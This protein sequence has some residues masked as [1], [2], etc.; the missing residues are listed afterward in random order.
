MVCEVMNMIVKNMEVTCRTKIKKTTLSIF[1]VLRRTSF[2]LNYYLITMAFKT[3]KRY[4]IKVTS[5]IF[6]K[7]KLWFH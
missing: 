2:V 6:A 5:L 1:V 3:T 4:S 7:K